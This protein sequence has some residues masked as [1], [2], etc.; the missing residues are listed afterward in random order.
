MAFS[1]AACTPTSRS[2]W[3]RTGATTRWCSRCYH[4]ATGSTDR[5]RRS[6]SR[7]ALPGAHAQ[8]SRCPDHRSGFCAAARALRASVSSIRAKRASRVVRSTRVPTAEPLRAPLI[9]SPS[10]WPGTVRVAIFGR[11]LGHWRHVGD[12][13]ASIGPPRPRAAGLARLTQRRQQLAPQGAAEQHRQA[14]IDGFGREVFPH[15]VRIRTLETSGNLF[16]RVA[17]S[18]M[19]PHIR[20]QPGIQEC[21]GSRPS[22]LA[23]V[24]SEWPWARPKLN[25]SRSSALMCRE[26]LFGMAT[27]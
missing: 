5:Q 3:A 4:A 12:V 14:H 21:A 1:H 19:L 2:P 16:G 18:Q 9:R 17:L 20:P 25:V 7:A 26:D 22:I 24:R 15:V 27:P 23:I 8:P 10:Q 11:T 6:G 13:A